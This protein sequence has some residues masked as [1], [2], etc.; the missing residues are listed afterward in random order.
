[1]ERRAREH[2]RNAYLMLFRPQDLI[3]DA[4]MGLREGFEDAGPLNGGRKYG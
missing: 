2:A 4:G 1:M 3:K